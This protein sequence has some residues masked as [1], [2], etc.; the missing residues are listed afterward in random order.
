MSKPESWF[1]SQPPIAVELA[2]LGVAVVII[3]MSGRIFLPQQ[4][5]SDSLALKFAVKEREVGQGVNTQ[6]CVAWVKFESLAQSH[7][8]H[9]V[10]QWPSEAALM[11]DL[12]I[13]VDDADRKAETPSDLALRKPGSL[14]TQ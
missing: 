8:S 10:R 11:C 9:P 12:K 7:F 14:E 2:E 5:T 3:G 13:L 1:E 6:R 4:E